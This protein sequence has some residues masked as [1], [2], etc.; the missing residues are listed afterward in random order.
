MSRGREGQ[1]LEILGYYHANGDRGDEEV[2][3]AYREICELEIAAQQT[4]S[5]ELWRASGNRWRIFIMV[6][7]GICK[8]WS[9]NGLVSYHMHD[10][11]ITDSLCQTLI[12]ATS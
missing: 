6:W 9:R 3:F 5:H 7:F 1:A 11:L 10:M 8:Q 2:K 12:T 4:K